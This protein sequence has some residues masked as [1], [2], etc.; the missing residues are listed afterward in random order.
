MAPARKTGKDHMDTSAP[1]KRIV[2]LGGGFG[3]VYTA[4]R[5]ESLVLT[6]EV[7][8]T[9]FEEYAEHRNGPRGREETGWLLLGHRLEREAREL[10]PV[11]YA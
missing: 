1:K 4:R 5:L 10:Y 11:E 7:S 9:L 3:G 8:R 2:I 6:D